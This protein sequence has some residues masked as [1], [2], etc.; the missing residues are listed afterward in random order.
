M[1]D[2]NK[3]PYTRNYFPSKKEDGSAISRMHD[4]KP[5]LDIIAGRQP[6]AEALKA[7]RLIE[8]IVVLYGVKGEGIERIKELA[9]QNR[10]PFVDVG[11]QK[12][13][14]LVS[15]TT[16]QGVAAIVGTKAYVE[17]DDILNVA[18]EKGEPPFLLIM[19]EIEDPHNLGAL[20]RSAEC[21]GMHGAI[22][23]KHHAA[24][25]NQTVIKTS[26]GASEH[27]AVA[28]VVNVAQTIDELKKQGVWFVGTDSDAE[29]SYT[30]IDYNGP[31]AIVV[32]SEGKGIRQLVKEKCDFVVKIPVYG[33][34][35][36]LNASVAGALVMFEAVKKRR[37]NKM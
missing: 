6:V 12:F 23:P 2:H 14:S 5:S 36:S 21:A 24:A 33:K 9:K 16:T 13:R 8:K 28:Q 22:I 32:G 17:I 4:R 35:G 20:L 11:K 34:V 31:L 7:G 10:V 27:I 3:K 25:V 37:V 30:E 19:D 26:A 18:K 15:D 1:I 29:K